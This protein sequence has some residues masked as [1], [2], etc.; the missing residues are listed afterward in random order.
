[1]SS[2]VWR[3]QERYLAQGI[4]GLTRDASHPGR[5]PPLAP[6]V[7]AQVVDK[8]LGEKPPAAT[9]WSTGRW[10]RPLAS[11]RPVCGGFGMHTR[12]SRIFCAVLRCRMTSDLVEKVQD[13][14]G[15]YLGPRTRRW[16]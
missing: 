10:P 6:E 1:M 2:G 12:S 5:K 16:C 7:I 13:V 3:W 15:L 14:V 8:T 11:A 4:A 9:Q